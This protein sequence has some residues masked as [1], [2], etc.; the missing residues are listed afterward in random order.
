MA[1]FIVDLGNIELTAAKHAEIAAAVQQAVLGH[2]ANIDNTIESNYVLFPTKIRGIIFR[3]EI[4]QLVEAQA[5]HLE[6]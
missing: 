1:R 6:S 2:L 3:P 5:K 4:S